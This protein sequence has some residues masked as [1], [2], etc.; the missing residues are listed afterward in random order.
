MKLTARSLNSQLAFAAKMARKV[1]DAKV[2]DALLARAAKLEADVSA[3]STVRRGR[4]YAMVVRRSP[5]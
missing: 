4:N 5:Q 2:R 3:V 1:P